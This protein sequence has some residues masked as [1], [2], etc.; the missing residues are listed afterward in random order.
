MKTTDYAGIDYGSGKSNYDTATGIRYGVISQNTPDPEAV[1]DIFERGT[2]LTF[3]AY[4]REAVDKVRSALSD[5][6]SD[7]KWDNK[8]SK[9]DNAVERVMYEI[10]DDIN[11]QYQPDSHDTL[12]EQDGYKITNCLDNDLMI[13]KS[14]YFT[15][16]QFCSP[17]VPGACNLDSPLSVPLNSEDKPLH[18]DIADQNKCY[19]LGH[20][21]FEDKKAPYPVYSVETGLPAIG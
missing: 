7:S 3:E 15:Y 10:V 1:Q 19:C 8:P 14:P 11:E 5:Y 21:W 20:D 13:L 9:L 17:C 6:F 2:D 16:A 4:Q 12:Y 18:P